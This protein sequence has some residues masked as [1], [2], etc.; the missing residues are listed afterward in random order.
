[1][2]TKRLIAIVTAAAAAFVF[3]AA[4]AFAADTVVTVIPG[5]LQG[6]SIE[7]TPGATPSPTATPSVTFVNGP[8]TPPAGSG[9]AEL[10]VGSDGGAVAQLR[11]AGYAGTVLPTPTPTPNPS[12]SPGDVTTYPAAANELT[13]LTYSTYVQQAGSG[14]QAPYIVLDVDYNGDGQRDDQLVFEPQYQGSAAC[15]GSGVSAGT[16]QT[17][18]TQERL[19]N[20]PQHPLARGCWYSLG[21][22]AGTGPG[23][24]KPLR[25]LMAARPNAKIVN[26]ATGA[27]GVRIVAGG[28][29]GAWDNFVGNVDKFR[30]GVGEDSEGSPNTTTYDFEQSAPAPP[31]DADVVVNKEANVS[32]SVA[33]R[34]VIY[35]IT[36]TNVGP[37]TATALTLTDTL[38]GNMTFVSLD[39]NDDWTCT[40]PNV[41]APNTVECTRASLP[42]SSPQVFT[43]VGHIPSNPMPNTVD[44]APPHDAYFTNTAQV[45]TGSNDPNPDSNTSTASTQLVSCLSSPMV[46]TNADAGAGSLRQAIQ[47]ACVGATVTFDM[48]SVV[49]PVTLTSGELLV[50]KNLTIQGPGANLLAVAR[51]GAASNF[52]VFNV[53]AGL[54]S[55]NISGLTISNGHAPDGTDN[56]ASGGVGGTGQNGGGILNASGS[57]L[58]LTGCAL[59]G[60]RAGTGGNATGS[61]ATGGL[62]G[63]GGGVYNSG[64]LNVND[65]TLSG[66]QSGDGGAGTANGGNGGNGGGLSNGVGATAAIT[67]STF[68]GNRSGNS[69]GGTAGFGGAVY[70]QAGLTLSSSTITANQT[71]TASTGG[72]GGGVYKSSGTT[73]IKNTIVAGNSAPGGQSPDVS[74]IFTSQGYNLVQDTTGATFNEAQNAGTNIPGVAPKLGALADNGGPTRTHRPLPDSPAVDKGNSFG[75]TAD[76]RGRPRPVDNNDTTFPDASGGD[77]SDIGAVETNYAISATAGTQQS[78]YPNADFAAQL[79][80]TLTES[81][82]PVSGITVTFTAPASGASATFPSGNA[83]ATDANGRASVAVRANA[84]PG[85]Y[86]VTANVTPALAP[87]ATFSLTNLAPGV[88]QFGSASYQQTEGGGLAVINVTRTGGSDG[89]ASVT[90]T[91]TAGTASGGASCGAPGTDFIPGSGTLSWADGDAADKTFAV[92]ICE[93]SS[94]EPDETVNLAL[95]NL[96]GQATFGARTTSTLTIND[97]DP[98]G[99]VISFSA[100]LYSVAERGGQRTVTVVRTGDTTR[101]AG[102][103]YATDDG[104]VPSVFVPCSATTGAAL[105]RCDYTRASGTLQFAANETS[106]TF[107]VLVND[108]SYV[109]GTETTTL[110]LSN[111]GGGAALGAQPTAALQIT[112]DAPESAGNPIDDDRNFVR[113]QYHDFLNR[114]PDTEGWDFWTNG[115][116]SCGADAGCREVKRIDTSAAFFLSIEFQQTGYFVYLT[117]KTSFGDI[118]GAPIPVRVREFLADTQQIGRGVVVNQ[119]DWQAQLEANKQAYLLSLV[120]SQEFRTRFP[121]S[122]SAGVFVN[123]LD[124][125]AGGVLTQGEKDSLTS[126][127]SPNPSD[128]GL[129]AS[130]LRKVATNQTLSQKEFNKAFVLMQYFGYLR[131]DPDSAPDTNFDGFNFWL[132]KL[133]QFGGDYRRA[134][135]VKAFLSSNEYRQRFGPQ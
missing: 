91:A 13:G 101:A 61:A 15:L 44:P 25:E 21:G 131:R 16:W 40:K 107:V 53:A 128:A 67:N 129:R 7:T 52:R 68:S 19:T 114:E 125:N 132:G 4:A 59:A 42:V 82:M 50:N 31:T 90:F 22:E 72:R 116:T 105:E 130:V 112:D 27:G 117:R 14:G 29:A 9:S 70:T 111:P 65:S 73:N 45:T 18:D 5:D 108:D 126:E 8:A 97:N 135:M 92:T 113:Q 98:R 121:D 127:L 133:N 33:D 118:P 55:V 60:N 87:A 96:T 93:D 46:T 95:S 56:P 41:T 102:V 76:Q 115:I 69:T 36:V 54:T 119:G 123:T 86:S 134:E 39:K 58:T 124:A 62:G 66:N 103:D 81:G 11:H 94:N 20:N 109:E 83:V 99:G 6:W 84:T 122:T 106:K 79:Q 57:T 24:V 89:A 49:S 12:A 64:T 100:A 26:S 38:P 37:D 48:D 71:G 63:D 47:D 35:T 1:M 74:G 32:A 120:Q 43:L 78:A 110:R 88:I 30:I 10:R 2:K 80:A 34:D 77:G 3:A 23:S 28:G 104:S 75:L 51:D 17:W 85:S